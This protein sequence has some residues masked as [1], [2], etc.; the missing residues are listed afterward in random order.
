[1][2][3]SDDDT[4]I[5]QMGIRG[6]KP[7]HIRNCLAEQTGYDLKKGDREGL[8]Q[9]LKETCTIEAETGAIVINSKNEDGEKTH[10][11]DDTWRTA[12]TS[13]KVASGFGQDMKDCVSSKVDADRDG[14]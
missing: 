6:V 10:I 7:S 13:Q 11:A 5:L 8:K 1:M 14:I 2:E 9:H 12:G 3:D 4:M